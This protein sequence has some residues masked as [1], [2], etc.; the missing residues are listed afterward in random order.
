VVAERAEGSEIAA[1]IFRRV[2]EITSWASR[3]SNIL[4]KPRSRYTPDPE[5]TESA[6]G[7]VEPE[8]RLNRKL[9]LGLLF[10]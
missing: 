6:E 2:M 5:V 3:R 7:E 10:I 4:G 8:A 9:A 1:P